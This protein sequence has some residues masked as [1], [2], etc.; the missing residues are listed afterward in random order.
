MTAIDRRYKT[1]VEVVIGLFLL[2]GLFYSIAV[3]YLL[4]HAIVESFT[5]LVTGSI[6]VIAWNS[7]RYLNNFYLLWIGISYAFISLLTL[8][9]MLAYSGMGLIP[10]PGANPATQLWIAAR[11]FE[12][13]SLITAVIFIHRRPNLVATMSGYIV[14]T[15]LIL[16]SIFKWQNF[17]TC[18]DDA[19]GKLTAFKV[20]SE[21]IICVLLVVAAYSLYKNRTH[22]DP[23]VFRQL[24]A[25]IILSVL[26][27]LAFTLY[28]DPYG[29][30][31]LIGHFLTFVSFYLVYKALIQTGLMRPYD[32]MFRE[33]FERE[34]ALRESEERFRLAADNIP[35][36]FYIYDSEMRI[37]FINSTGLERLPRSKEELIG[38]REQDFLPQDQ[39]DRFLPSLKKAY[40][41][42][43][44]QT[45][46]IEAVYPDE[47]QHSLI[48]SY[49]P[50]LDENGEILQVLGIGHDITEQK[51]AEAVLR[52]SRDEL[53]ELVALRTQKLAAAN[54][55]LSENE[56]RLRGLNAALEHRATQLRA[57]ASELTKS[58]ERERRRLAHYL[59][60]HLQQLLV[61]AR[62]SATMALRRSIEEPQQKDIERTMDLLAQS[63]DAGRS[64]TMELSP[65][66]LLDSGIG[67]GLSWLA[68]WMQE[69]HGLNVTVQIDETIGSLAEDKTLLLFNAAREL[70]F[71]IVK[72][73]ETDS[74][75]VVLKNDR[76][77]NT[78]RIVIAD[79]GKGFDV[80]HQENE[81]ERASFGL[82]SIRERLAYMDGEMVINSRPGEGTQIELSI[83]MDSQTSPTPGNG[84]ASKPFAE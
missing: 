70:L 51:Q 4:F 73:A 29:S 71:N 65:P 61:A 44:T 67:A 62:F 75:E 24:F 77:N 21:Y 40:E 66:V 25:A 60:D 17:P 19:A 47:K 58:E 34:K 2:A 78:I 53:E 69:K 5:I 81:N 11:Y 36:V 79:H 35:E 13:I 22:F 39:L 38:K 7:R 31:N 1:I 46:E 8:L 56:Q 33:L 54:E 68:R 64:L 15:A 43:Q 45:F 32:L 83:S 30:L 49:V 57:M 18:Y 52:R 82:F 50:M 63:I 84:S 9:H 12:A 16:F 80:E 23:S 41:T 72:H 76:E 55:Q 10:L 3:G 14:I 37:K 27:E 28:Q 48:V 42:K 59:H 26:A 74:A 6:F 20:V